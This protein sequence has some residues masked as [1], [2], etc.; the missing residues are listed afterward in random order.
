MRNRGNSKKTKKKRQETTDGAHIA[1]CSK[2]MYHPLGSRLSRV[3]LIRP[4]PTR[5]G[6]VVGN[7]LPRQRAVDARC[8][9]L[10]TCGR[11][12]HRTGGGGLPS[13][14]RGHRASRCSLEGPAHWPSSP[15]PGH[16]DQVSPWPGWQCKR[17]RNMSVLH[18]AKK[19]YHKNAIAVMSWQGGAQHSGWAGATS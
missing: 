7:V 14:C 18:S 19:P 10:R 9:S 1:A 2:N 12:P 8:R 15:P 6:V 3:N 11:T 5:G 4:V 16:Y 13:L 17:Q